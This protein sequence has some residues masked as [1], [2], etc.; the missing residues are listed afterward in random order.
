MTTT[1]ALNSRVEV[2]VI[3]AFYPKHT[4]QYLKF[5]TVEAIVSCDDMFHI[6]LCILKYIFLFWSM[7]LKIFYFFM[8]H[9]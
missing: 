8:C 3:V 6:I 5:S 4:T 2:P 1:V 9:F 7:P